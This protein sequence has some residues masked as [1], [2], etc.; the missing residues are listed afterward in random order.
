MDEKRTPCVSLD[1]PAHDNEFGDLEGYFLADEKSI[2]LDQS[3]F[4]SVT[5]PADWSKYIDQSI[6]SFGVF[7]E[8]SKSYTFIIP[9]KED[10]EAM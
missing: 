5:P 4:D 10:W 2:N 8:D 6:K 3:L 9:I 1:F 7:F